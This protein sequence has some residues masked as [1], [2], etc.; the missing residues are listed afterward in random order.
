MANCHTIANEMAK[1]FIEASNKKYALNKILHDLNFIVY[2]DTKTLLSYKHK[3]I[4]IENIFEL[5]V[6]RKKFS[7]KDSN[8]QL[9]EITD[10]LVFIERKNL[11]RNQLRTN[12]PKLAEMN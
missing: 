1:D 9:P 8:Q 6:G 3:Q 10:V 11:I 12:L 7:E 4:I 2:S 5:L